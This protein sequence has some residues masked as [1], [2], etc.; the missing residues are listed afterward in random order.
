MEPVVWAEDFAGAGATEASMRLSVGLAGLGCGLREEAAG[1]C[2]GSS[3]RRVR[4]ISLLDSRRGARGTALR[5]AAG[6]L[7]WGTSLCLSFCPF[8]C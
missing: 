6:L 1:L 5:L 7:A 8:K 4:Q 2:Q 3:P